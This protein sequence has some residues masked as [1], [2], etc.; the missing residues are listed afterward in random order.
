MLGLSKIL[1]RYEKYVFSYYPYMYFALNMM[2]WTTSLICFILSVCFTDCLLCL[3]L[4]TKINSKTNQNVILR[5]CQKYFRT[6]SFG[7]YLLSQSVDMYNVSASKSLKC[8]VL[9]VVRHLNLVDFAP[10]LCTLF[11]LRP[12]L[13]IQSMMY[14]IY[15]FIYI[16][17]TLLFIFFLLFY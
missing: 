4:F 11:S 13:L 14:I 10:F 2:F 12:F 15:S 8:Q 9:T 16:L 5:F 6:N 7:S 1:L 3:L 17:F